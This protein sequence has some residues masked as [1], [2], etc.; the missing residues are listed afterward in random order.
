MVILGINETHCATAAVLRDGKIVGCTSEERFTRVKNDAGYP[1]RA[2]DALLASL[3][4]SP[5]D[6]DLVALAGTRM[7]A[8]EWLDRVLQDE[9]YSREY[10]G[11]RLPSAQRALEKRF[12]K[13]GAKFGLM[14]ASRGKFGMT[15]TERLALVTEHLGISTEKIACLDHH[16]CHAA[17]AYFGSPYRGAPALVMTNDNSGDG[18]CATVSTAQG[19]RL[20]RHEA[21][22]SAPGSLGAFYSFVTLYLGMKFGEHEYKVM[23]LAPYASEPGRRRAYQILKELF[24]LH[25]G[26]PCRFEWKRRGERYQ[27]LLRACLGL[28]FDWVAAGAQELL[29]EIL[30]RWVSIARSRRGGSRLALGGGVFMNVKANMLIA[31]EEG[32]EDLFVFPSCGDES[33]AIGAAYLAYLEECARRGMPGTPEP[34]GPAYLGPEATDEE[35]EALI[36]ERNLDARYKVGVHDRMEE[37][38]ADLL[39]SDGVVA[40]CSGRMEFGA[41]AL[42]NRSI[43]ANPSDQRVVPLINRMI[44]NRDFWMPFAPT[45]LKE[46]EGDYLVNPKGL[47]S[48]YMM[49]A[50]PTHGKRQEELIAAIHPQDATA[51][52]QILEES[53]NPEYYRI[54]RE[55]ERRTGIGAV[56]NTSFNLHGEPIVYSPADAVDTFERS[57]LPHLALGRFLISKR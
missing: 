1:R 29:E 15:Q 4:L 38:I 50:F 28:R 41:R 57:G 54:I 46:R 45:I 55:F 22:S 16:T 42:G 21:T 32:I 48:P 40:H 23:G 52:P 37:K 26:T 20:T 25:E 51:R 6:I 39:V 56:L 33:N 7:V 8:K 17:A 3:G 24:D 30:V 34:L 18:L 10:Y 49:L 47:P 36:R 9:D 43:L 53:W 27:L 31:Q 12:R 35:I 14:D 19:Q 44:K 11:V 5:R 2:V 13:L